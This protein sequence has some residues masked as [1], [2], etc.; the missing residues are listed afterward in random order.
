MVGRIGDD[1]LGEEI[2]ENLQRNKV[3]V[4]YV[5][6]VADSTSERHILHFVIMIIVLS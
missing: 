4:D 2:Y 5:K 6:P 1:Q 3:R